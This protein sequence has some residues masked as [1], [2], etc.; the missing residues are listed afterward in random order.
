MYLAQLRPCIFT[1][2]SERF[3]WNV[4]C[5][6]VTHLLWISEYM[7][8]KSLITSPNQYKFFDRPSKQ[9]LWWPLGLVTENIRILSYWVSQKLTSCSYTFQSLFSHVFTGMW[10]TIENVG[11]T[12][13]IWGRKYSEST[14]IVNNVLCINSLVFCPFIVLRQ[15]FLIRGFICSHVNWNNSSTW[16][17][18]FFL[19][20]LHL[21]HGVFK[22]S[23][24]WARIKTDFCHQNYIGEVLCWCKVSV[25]FSHLSRTIDA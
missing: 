16:F 25:S 4:K 1:H 17:W 24:L 15:Q 12:M 10:V 14:F 23:L 13:S 9:Q 19:F 20:K 22:T 18:M 7:K 5:S 21:I 2:S 8:S 11:K 3:Q 6:L